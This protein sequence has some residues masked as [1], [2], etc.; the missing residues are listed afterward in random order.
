MDRVNQMNSPVRHRAARVVPEVTKRRKCGRLHSPAVGVKRNQRGRPKP[1]VPIQIRRR[2][3]V[4][5]IPETLPFREPALKSMA[6][7]D[8]ARC[9]SFDQLGRLLEVAS[10]ALHSAALDDSL[11]LARGLNHLLALSHIHAGRLLYVNVFAGL[12]RL[13][14][15][16]GVPMV[17]RRDAHRVNGFVGQYL[18][19]ILIGPRL[20]TGLRRSRCGAFQ[21]WRVHITNRNRLRAGANSKVEVARTHGTKTDKTDG[22]ALI[23]SLK[24]ASEKRSGK[25]SARA[26]KQV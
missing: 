20:L 17:R 4:R 21:M 24:S 6:E 18:A 7:G 1:H 15:H 9:P 11:I 16:I 5:R 14:G 22:N 26:G 12:T 13:D 23:S 25:G 19:K 3:T 8:L 10:R 2:I